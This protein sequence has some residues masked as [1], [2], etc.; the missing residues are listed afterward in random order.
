MTT[1]DA[2]LP[3][4]VLQR[5]AEPRQAG[6]AASRLRQCNAVLRH[7]EHAATRELNNPRL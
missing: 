1:N 7:V 6:K 3:A 2:L 5:K 4:T